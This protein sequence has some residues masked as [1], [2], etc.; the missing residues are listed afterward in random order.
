[1]NVQALTTGVLINC[2]TVPKAVKLAKDIYGIDP[3]VSAGKSKRNGLV[4]RLHAP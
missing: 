3:A 1:M 2:G 4:A